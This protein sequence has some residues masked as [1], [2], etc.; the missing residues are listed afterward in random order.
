MGKIMRFSEFSV[1][2][3]TVPADKYWQIKADQ[4]KHVFKNAGYKIVK[5]QLDIEMIGKAESP[6]LKL[7]LDKKMKP[8]SE[9]EIALKIRK[10]LNLD[11]S[12]RVELYPDDGDDKNIVVIDLFMDL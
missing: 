12:P 9:R 6:E 5:D 7:N 3:A 1:N 4:I 10:M 8:G 11:D 2:E